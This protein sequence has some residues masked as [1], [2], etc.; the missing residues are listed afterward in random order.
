M[1]RDSG[2]GKSTAIILPEQTESLKEALMNEKKLVQ[3]TLD[4][5]HLGKFEFLICEAMEYNWTLTFN[6]FEN[7]YVENINGNIQYVDPLNRQ[8][9][10]QDIDYKN[11]YIPLENVIDLYRL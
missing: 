5:Q 10:I 2:T 1:L 9:R 11:H 6:V 7:G 8:L 4:E 3:P